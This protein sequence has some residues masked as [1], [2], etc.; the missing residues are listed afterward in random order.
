LEPKPQ[1]E[2]HPT[3]WNDFC[4]LVLEIIAEL[5][6]CSESK[7]FI[8][9][10]NRRLERFGDGSLSDVNN[11]L[12]QCV[13]ELQARGLV[14]I[15]GEQLVI[16]T[17]ASA[18]DEDILDLTNELE[19]HPST[20][21]EASI[22]QKQ[23]KLDDV[24]EQP[25]T[26]TLQTQAP[27]TGDTAAPDPTG[28]EIIAAAPAGSAVDNDILDLT[29]ELA[30]SAEDEEILNLTTEL[31]GS[32]EDEEILNLT[33]ELVGSAED[34]EILDLT[35]ELV[36][37]AEDEEILD[38]TNELVESAEDEEILDLTN[39]LELHPSTLDE[40]SI[41]QKQA[42]LDDVRE[43]PRTGTLQT[44]APVTGDTA[45]PDPTREEIIAAMRKFIS[46]DPTGKQPPQRDNASSP[47]G[48]KGS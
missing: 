4:R 32:A 39:E 41:N 31:A 33:T 35:N 8:V 18:E 42:Q 28:E 23:A 14:E 17:P 46:D 27:V 11:L 37:S 44:Q 12:G 24:W 25:R 9:A 34:E 10:A 29:T 26:G 16:A 21:D 6:P 3:S 43:Q 48:R 5:S 2:S 20:L 19:L 1:A 40:A 7:L 36:E 15:T 45:A 30:G 13:Q 22:N 47:T 38:L